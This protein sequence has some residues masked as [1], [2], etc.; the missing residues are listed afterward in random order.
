M[1]VSDRCFHQ[2]LTYV[3]LRGDRNTRVIRVISWELLG[4]GLQEVPRRLRRIDRTKSSLVSVL[5]RVGTKQESGVLLRC[6]SCI[7]KHFDVTRYQ[8]VRDVLECIVAQAHL[9]RLIQKQHVD[10]VVPRV[11]AEV[12]R[13]GVGVDVA[14]SILDEE[15]QHGGT[16]GATV[17]PNCLQSEGFKSVLCLR[18]Y[19]GL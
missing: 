1:L 5:T 14:W 8:I 15:A 17:H 16:A 4:E 2:E 18:H 13:V 19:I 7:I 11:L 10:L 6:L 9:H 12:R 3:G